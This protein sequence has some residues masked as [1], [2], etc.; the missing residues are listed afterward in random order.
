MDGRGR[1]REGDPRGAD[2][3]VLANLRAQQ[4]FAPPPPA[5]DAPLLARR[6]ATLSVIINVDAILSLLIPLFLLS[7]K[8]AFLLFIFGRHASPSKRIALA[9]IAVLWIFYEGWS[10]HRRRVQAMRERERAERERRRANRAQAAVQL[11]S[12][13]RRGR[14][15]RRFWVREETSCSRRRFR[16]GGRG[17]GRRRGILLLHPLLR[18]YLPLAGGLE[19]ERRTDTTV[20][21]RLRACRPSIG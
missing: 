13:R 14:P 10:I 5:A 8:L 12:R 9:C 15:R 11:G 1:P 19:Q 16:M 7:L 6:R 3:A 21:R 20:E 4:R 17:S 2:A 18:L